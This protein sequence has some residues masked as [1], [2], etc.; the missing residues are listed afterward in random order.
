MWSPDDEHWLTPQVFGVG[1]TVNLGR[2]VSV[3][4]SQRD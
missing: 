4:T 1:W 2:L 3:L